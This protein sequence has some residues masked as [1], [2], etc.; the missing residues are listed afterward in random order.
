MHIIWSQWNKT[1]IHQQKKQLK[2]WKQLEDEHHIAQQSVGHRRNRE[3]IKK[4][5]EIIEN[6][7]TTYQNLWNTAR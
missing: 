1:K 6:E 7:N 5:L 3:E 2:I 4:F